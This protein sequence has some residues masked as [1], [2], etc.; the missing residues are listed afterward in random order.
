MHTW[1]VSPTPAGHIVADFG[2]RARLTEDKGVSTLTKGDK[3]F[4]FNGRIMA[5][6]ANLEENT[7][8]YKDF[9]WLT[10]PEIQK[11]VT[12]WYWSKVQNILRDR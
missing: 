11:H 9:K 12:R 4:L 1:I 6:Q 8:G 7:L 5:G 3:T 10:K 2:E